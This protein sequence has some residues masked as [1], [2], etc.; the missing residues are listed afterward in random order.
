MYRYVYQSSRNPGMLEPI[1]PDRS[2]MCADNFAI[3]ADKVQFRQYELR[4]F[5]MSF[6]DNLDI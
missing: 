6:A 1:I 4:D 3:F 5:F 2:H